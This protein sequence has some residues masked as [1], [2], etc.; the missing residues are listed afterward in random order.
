MTGLF[1]AINTTTDS[2]LFGRYLCHMA[3]IL[4]EKTGMEFSLA[5]MHKPIIIAQA[6][7]ESSV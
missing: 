3:Q 4:H 1:D 2:F 5:N 6:A 7:L